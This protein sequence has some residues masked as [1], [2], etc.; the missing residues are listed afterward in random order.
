MDTE[1]LN[2]VRSVL[3]SIKI[4]IPLPTQT[5]EKDE[6]YKIYGLEYYYPDSKD[7]KDALHGGKNL[8]R[9]PR[10][11]GT[12]E[13]T[14]L[15]KNGTTIKNRI[16]GLD[17]FNNLIYNPRDMYDYI[18]KYFIKPYSA[19]PDNNPFV[20]S[21]G[22]INKTIKDLS[23][24][25]DLNPHQKF[26][27]QMMS[28]MTDFN[29][30]LLYHGL[31]SGKTLSDIVM[32]ESLKA[33]YINS[34]DSRGI[35]TIPGRNSSCTITIA[36]PKN[37]L[38]TY[39]EAI[40]GKIEDG[41]PQSFTSLCVIYSMEENNA[42]YR[43]FYTGT[44]KKDHNGNTI[45]HNGFVEYE[46]TTL[47]I[48]KQ[49]ITARDKLRRHES[50]L[51]DDYIKI[52]RDNHGWDIKQKQ[53]AIDSNTNQKK[54]TADNISRLNI[55][56]K[57]LENTLKDRI[58]QVYF[59]VSFDTLISRLYNTKGS[60][61]GIKE[62]MFDSN[63]GSFSEDVRYGEPPHTDCFHS[64]ESVL[65]IDEIHRFI[66]EKIDRLSGKGSKHEA[67]YN[68]LN[69]YARLR[70]G[71]PAMK[72]VASTATPIFD[73]PSQLG[74]IINL[75]RPRISFPSSQA[76]FNKWFIRG[77]AEPKNT[78]LFKYML[79]GYVSY[80]KGGNPVGYPY[81]RNHI[82][83]HPII[84]EQ[85]Q[86][87]I[88]RLVKLEKNKKNGN[89][90]DASALRA[91]TSDLLCVF[92]D[93]NDNVARSKDIGSV[94]YKYAKKLQDRMEEI[95]KTHGISAVDMYFK[96]HA[97]KLYEV[98]QLI[99]KSN[100]NSF[101]YSSLIARGLLP[102]AYYL[103]IHGYHLLDGKDV[104]H[105]RPKSFGIYSG[106]AS[107][108]D[109]LNLSV[110]GGGSDG[111]GAYK[112]KLI[113]TFN[114]DENI[115]GSKCKIIL[116]LIQEGIT[117]LNVQSIHICDPWWNS[118][119][120]EQVIGRGIRYL[121]HRKLPENRQYVDV[122]YHAAVFGTY[123]GHCPE[124]K[125][126]NSRMTIDQIMYK[127]TEG[128][129]KLNTKFDQLTK[130]SSIDIQLNRYGNLS[131]LEEVIIYKSTKERNF[132]VLLNRSNY[133]YYTQ[134]DS[135]IVEIDMI[136]RENA[137]K[138][139]T[140]DET[141]EFDIS[142]LLGSLN[143]ENEEHEEEDNETSD[144]IDD[145]DK[146][147]LRRIE[148]EKLIWPPT[149]YTITDKVLNDYKYSESIDDQN[150]KMISIVMR[151]VL[152]DFSKNTSMNFYDLKNYAINNGEDESIWKMAEDTYI[153][154]QT[155]SNMIGMY[156]LY[157]M[158]P[159]SLEMQK[160]I[161]I[162]GTYIWKILDQSLKEGLPNYK[163]VYIAGIA[164]LTQLNT[165]PHLQ[166]LA[167]LYNEKYHTNITKDDISSSDKLKEHFNM[168]QVKFLVD[169]IPKVEKKKP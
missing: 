157:K 126:G 45:K 32:A 71:F 70:S 127:T 22:Y 110:T 54:N 123:P 18:D 25:S 8:P 46:D 64:K 31:G 65:I 74:H 118:S 138:R 149:G 21:L 100:G 49:K 89:D 83:L 154:S 88:N 39:V 159:D 69:I 145:L 42:G 23:S 113:D 137:I 139:D 26:C 81:R 91:C 99:M 60:K 73:R 111:S 50:E 28:S 132:S 36:V 47:K 79:S 168:D 11:W 13:E 105:G 129:T 128:K 68:I 96:K 78:I 114:S 150:R 125:G 80:F 147:Q 160:F 85:S 169:N 72:I 165:K 121:S 117:F 155:V 66:T 51:Q 108:L 24:V 101:V 61:G 98:A 164:A 95:K 34:S 1:A 94:D 59:L 16:S 12:Y 109:Y 30:I 63:W 87:Y 166:Q 131:R 5:N 33:S 77:L 106:T 135:K 2:V 151:E 120:I 52:M 153:R 104:G 143:A 112:S 102:L 57:R 29:G 38:K 142:E 40:T 6:N 115:D 55:E 161:K 53:S 92:P 158:D 140:T 133:V 107:K 37:M 119:R 122:Y 14:I 82:M 156:N 148:K 27:G 58:K 84:G 48:Q 43:Q 19:N 130:Q 167:K 15:L 3:S 141:D 76:E 86:V 9:G 162:Y 103:M 10:P 35:S 4:N 17:A 146:F 67:L 41:K 163:T 116:G 93:Q 152:E 124:L 134:K 90:I 7:M 20:Y 144:Q 62:T 56:I 136:D 75:L 97:I 44:V